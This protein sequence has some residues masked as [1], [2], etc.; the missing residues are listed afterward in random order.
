MHHREKKRSLV[1]PIGLGYQNEFRGMHSRETITSLVV[2]V[3]VSQ[4]V[5]FSSSGV[6]AA[7]SSHLQ[8]RF[9]LENEARHPSVT[10]K[11]FQ[12]RSLDSRSDSRAKMTQPAK[13]GL[14]LNRESCY[15]RISPK[16]LLSKYFLDHD[17]MYEWEG[18]K[19]KKTERYDVMQ[20]YIDRSVCRC[21]V[22][23]VRL[24]PK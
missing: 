2:A 20:E 7:L 17:V 1:S 18:A 23:R 10:S 5:L 8:R 6:L 9:V 24:S 4:V 14:F 13:P 22:Q 11:N 21:R 12:F 15:M 3:E 19:K 16:K